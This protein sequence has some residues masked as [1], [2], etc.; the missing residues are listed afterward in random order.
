MSGNAWYGPGGRSGSE[1]TL[2]WQT[3]GYSGDASPELEAEV[4]ERGS[5]GE[6]RIR[7]AP[8]A[9]FFARVERIGHVPLPPYIDRSDRADDRERYQTVY[10]QTPGS[11]QDR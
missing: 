11:G 10:A 9:D 5:F 4:T 1:K 2:L 8:V 3:I 7:F 6:R